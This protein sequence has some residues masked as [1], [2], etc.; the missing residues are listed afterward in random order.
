[1]CLARSGALQFS[2]LK[3]GRVYKRRICAHFECIFS[4]SHAWIKRTHFVS[5]DKTVFIHFHKNTFPV[6]SVIMNVNLLT[7]SIFIYNG[8]LNGIDQFY[9]NILSIISDDK[10]QT[11]VF[12]LVTSSVVLERVHAHRQT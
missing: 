8:Y 4:S 9:N 3:V 2:T 10:R 5:K 1:M 7:M 6:A 11:G 12:H